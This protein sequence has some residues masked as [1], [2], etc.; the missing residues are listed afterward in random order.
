MTLSSAA[1][2][3]EKLVIDNSPTILTGIAVAGTVA[4]AVL[5]GKATFQA[6]K[7]LDEEVAS[8]EQEVMPIKEQ[9]KILVPKVW[10]LYIPPAI[11]GVLTIVSIVGVNSIGNRRAA[12]IA[13]AYSVSEKAFEEYRAKVAEKLGEPKER[14]VRDELAQDR[15]DQNPV[16]TR[17]VIVAGAGEVL[18]Y[19]AFTGRYFKS[20]MEELKKAQNDLNYKVLNDYY[21]SLSDFYDLIG[22]PRTDYSDEVGW[23]CNKQMELEFST[24]LADDGR[25][26]IS[27][28]F[29]VHP[30]RDYFRLS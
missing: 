11:T 7:I 22:L 19:E 24:T 25:P 20:S 6:A 17:E 8:W 15:V 28:S 2:H 5:T 30:I 1:K 13:A 3:L 29:A 26:C 18:C 10:R 12:A 14:A 21:A 27:I 9:A 4:T 23:N 16:S